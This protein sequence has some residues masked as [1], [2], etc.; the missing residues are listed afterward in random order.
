[1]IQLLEQ[2]RRRGIEIAPFADIVPTHQLDDADLASIA[3]H[4]GPDVSY[5]KGALYFPYEQTTIGFE[6]DTVTLEKRNVL[7]HGAYQ[8]QSFPLD[9]THMVFDQFGRFHF[10]APISHALGREA[11]V[12]LITVSAD[13]VALRTV[14]ARNGQFR[15]LDPSIIH[16]ARAAQAYVLHN[17]EVI[18]SAVRNGVYEKATIMP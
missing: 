2:G 9:N 10:V 16:V 18:D 8:D 14:R 12:S 3:R 15:S 11:T 13:E 5:Q 17:R 6:H 7:V 4:I 1:M